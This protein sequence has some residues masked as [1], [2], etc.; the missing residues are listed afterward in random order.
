V[1]VHVPVA[2]IV[3]RIFVEDG[4]VVEEGQP[5]AEMKSP[6]L[7]SDIIKTEDMVREVQ[8]NL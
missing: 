2:G 1:Q 7:E 5:I 3:E 4:C 8:A 6:S